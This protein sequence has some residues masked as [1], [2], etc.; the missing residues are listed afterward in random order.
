MSIL[1]SIGSPQ[2]GLVLPGKGQGDLASDEGVSSTG[3][4]TE[5]NTLFV[6]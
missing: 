1:P 2:K 5:G 4:L 3:I 6:P